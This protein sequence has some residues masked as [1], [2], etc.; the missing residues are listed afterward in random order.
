M[1]TVCSMYFPLN[2][3]GTEC[4]WVTITVGQIL[5]AKLF[6]ILTL[7]VVDNL[8]FNINQYEKFSGVLT[9]EAIFLLVFNLKTQKIKFD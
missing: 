6:S 9:S 8:F 7:D 3:L 1:V 5:Y 2:Q 4:N